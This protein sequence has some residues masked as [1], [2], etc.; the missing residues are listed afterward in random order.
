MKAYSDPM[1]FFYLI[2]FV[3]LILFFI[4]CTDT[5]PV[6]PVPVP[7]PTTEDPLP[8]QVTYQEHM[9]P[10]FKEKCQMCHNQTTPDKNWMIYETA[11]KKRDLIKLRISNRTMPLGLTLTDRQRNLI[12]KWVD[13][14]AKK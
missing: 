5:P 11:Y 3:L 4:S 13:T 1:R 6:A 7:P 14:G 9:L 2:L 12:I 8:D 10:L